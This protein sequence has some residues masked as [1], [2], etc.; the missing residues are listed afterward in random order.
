MKLIDLL[1]TS[2]RIR[3]ISK[4][5]IPILLGKLETLKA[6]LW[7]RLT[8]L[9]EPEPIVVFA[10]ADERCA[11]TSQNNVLAFRHDDIPGP[12]GRILR[13]KEVIRMTGLSRTTLWLMER[14]GTFPK[15]RQIG[16]RSVGWLDTQVHEWIRERGGMSRQRLTLYCSQRRLAF[17][18]AVSA[19]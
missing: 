12:Q 16:S 5:E 17:V 7:V 8:E 4:D 2:R 10:K 3:T 11:P 14:A 19:V 1:I 6:R 18:F 15:H 9:E 13:A